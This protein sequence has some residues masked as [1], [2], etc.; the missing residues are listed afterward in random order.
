MGR[1]TA[2]AGTA[3]RGRRSG[4]VGR[5]AERRGRQIGLRECDELLPRN[6][7]MDGYC[8]GD[9]EGEGRCP[10]VMVMMRVMIGRRAG[11]R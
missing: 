4:I 2:A 5:R 7:P 1:S 10:M 9:S 11:G 8:G 6:G 3:V